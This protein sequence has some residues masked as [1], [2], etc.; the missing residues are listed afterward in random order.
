MK[1]RKLTWTITLFLTFTILLGTVTM[2]VSDKYFNEN[3]P[4]SVMKG[5]IQIQLSED[6]VV[7]INQQEHRYITPNKTFEGDPYGIVK[8]FMQKE[9]WTFQS[10]QKG[11]LT[12]IKGDETTSVK[13]KPF[14]SDYYIFDITDHS[15]TLS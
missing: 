5:I 9:G 8:Q 11:V 13:T 2:I 15:E 10:Q 14:T 1:K 12:F 4:Y 6:S 3:N 7:N